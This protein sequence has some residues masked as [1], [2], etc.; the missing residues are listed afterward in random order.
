MA[1]LSGINTRLRGS[2][3]DWTFSRL[4]GQ[5]VAKQKVE[6]KENPK[7][8]FAQMVRRVQWANLVA[9]YQAFEGNL[10]P[11]FENKGVYYQLNVPRITCITRI[12]QAKACFFHTNYHELTMNGWRRFLFLAEN[13]ENAEF[14][15]N[16]PLL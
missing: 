2:V 10:H 13:A 6:A 16:F 5:T 12:W 4:N 3:G 15:F 9:L 1:I 7:R 8:T 11:S 14:T